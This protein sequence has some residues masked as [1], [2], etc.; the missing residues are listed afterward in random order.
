[1]PSQRS[2]CPEGFNRATAVLN[3]SSASPLAVITPALLSAIDDSTP[4]GELVFSLSTDAK[5]GEVLLNGTSLSAGDSFT[6]QDIADGCVAYLAGASN[7]TADSIGITVTDTDGISAVGT[8][9]VSLPSFDNVQ[10][11]A[12]W[13]G[14]WGGNGRDLLQGT[15]RIDIMTGGK[16]DD[17]M[18][19]GSGFDA[20]YGGRGNDRMDGG[21]G[22]DVLIGDEGDDWIEGGS[23]T[24]II[25]AGSGNDV[26]NGGTGDWDIL[27]GSAGRDVYVFHQGDGKDYVEGLESREGDVIDLRDFS[28]V[29]G[30][31]NSWAE[32]RDTPGMVQSPP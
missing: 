6:S 26:L 28:G 30:S 1:M 4:V 10:T 23:G 8:I 21:A 12:R 29:L 3:L 24:D 16:G 17:V 7:A 14:Y 11:T 13:G 19:G 9:A 5:A 20:L 25:Y 32:L 15:D 22:S 2:T 31:I 18:L 27:S